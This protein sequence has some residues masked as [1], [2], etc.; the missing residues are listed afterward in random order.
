MGVPVAPLHILEQ[1]GIPPLGGSSWGGVPGGERPAVMRGGGRPWTA[2]GLDKGV[3]PAAGL[4]R[5]L[6][7]TRSTSP[8]GCGEGV[9]RAVGGLPPSGWV[10]PV[11]SRVEASGAGM[12]L[13]VGV[14][15]W[16]AVE[17]PYRGEL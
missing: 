4:W 6:R 15:Q 12:L 13:R 8:C 10:A 14:E 9:S 3:V 11:W 16:I 17:S 2:D 5:P 7:A 1:R